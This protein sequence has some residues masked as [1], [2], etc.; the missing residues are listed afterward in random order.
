MKLKK[1]FLTFAIIALLSVVFV[2]AISASEYDF[3]S[4]SDNSD[5]LTLPAMSVSTFEFDAAGNGSGVTFKY[6]ID[7]K[8]NFISIRPV[9]FVRIVNFMNNDIY[10][11]TVFIEGCKSA[12]ETFQELS[13][14]TKYFF[15]LWS[16]GYFGCNEEYFNKLYNYTEITQSDIDELQA[17]IDNKSTEI[18]NLEN[19]NLKLEENLAYSLNQVTTLSQSRG[20]LLAVNASLE[21]QLQNKINLAYAQ[22]LVDSGSTSDVVPVLIGIITLLEGVALV[23]LIVSKIKNRKKGR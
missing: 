21:K 19:A 3:I 9:D 7:N 16:N 8:N 2:T 22:G 6:L 20:E 17:T 5:D 1:F 15:V 23:I 12:F 13:D 14:D 10:S 4:S 11:Y 18:I